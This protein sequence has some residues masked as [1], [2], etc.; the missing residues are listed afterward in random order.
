MK[1]PTS[2][3]YPGSRLIVSALIGLLAIAS[4]HAGQFDKFKGDY[5][6]K[7]KII[8]GAVTYESKADAVFKV[9]SSSKDGKLKVTATELGKKVSIK[10]KLKKDGTCLLKLTPTDNLTIQ[11]SGTQVVESKKLV[12]FFVATTIGGVEV[13][14]PGRLEMVNNK[15]LKIS[16]SMSGV[17]PV[18]GQTVTVRYNYQGKK[19]KK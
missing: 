15:K 3:V 16:G 18:S 13:S 7:A 17:S 1:T 6:G 4:A 14:G 5:E 19:T 12:T 10:L 9:G 11:A 8:P 2:T